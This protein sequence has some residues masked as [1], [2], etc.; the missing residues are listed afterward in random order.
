MWK[1]NSFSKFFVYVIKNI[2]CVSAVV[3]DEGAHSM[4]V[5]C[6]LDRWVVSEALYQFGVL[7]RD[8]VQHQKIL[9]HQFRCFIMRTFASEL[10]IRTITWRGPPFLF[11]GTRCIARMSVEF[12]S[13]SSSQTTG[14]SPQAFS[15][16]HG[17]T[18][19]H[20]PVYIKNMHEPCK[21]CKPIKFHPSKIYSENPK[22][23]NTHT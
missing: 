17:S 14:L 9:F 6:G 20:S 11:P 7:L 19:L 12:T 3:F 5:P 8:V 15:S 21:P 1:K 16:T 13:M 10:I 4:K 18:M 23:T 2:E 22:L